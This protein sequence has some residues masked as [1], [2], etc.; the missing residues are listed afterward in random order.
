MPPRRRLRAVVC[1]DN[2]KGSCKAERV[3]QAIV[4]GLSAAAPQVDWEFDAVPMT[5]GGAGFLS[6]LVAA[7][8]TLEVVSM[9][10]II[11]PLQHALPHA[12]YA[13]DRQ[14][15]HAFIEM[16]AAAGIEHVPV[17]ERNPLRTTTFGVG[18]MIRHAVQRS[19]ATKVT[20]GL[21]GSA[22]N[23]GALGML[24]ALG[25]ALILRRKDGKEVEM[26]NDGSEGFAC[27]QTLLELVSIKHADRVL[28]TLRPKT[29]A[30]VV[31]VELVTDVTNVLTGAHGATAVYG[32]QKG[33]TAEMVQ[34]LDAAMKRYAT[35]LAR[36]FGKD[37]ENEPGAGAA[38]G[39]GAALIAA[40]NAVPHRGA[41]AFASMVKLKQRM[42]D[43]DVVITGEGCFDQQTLAYGKTA[44][45]VMQLAKEVALRRGTQ[46]PVVVV[47]G[48][49]EVSAEEAA[50]HGVR[51]TL[52]LR[53]M[54]SREEAVGETQRCIREMLTENVSHVMR[55][56]T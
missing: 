21:G 49:K 36:A 45:V 30:P 2:F 43:A 25:A 9:S 53:D 32:P 52:V 12:V 26:L 1:C 24:Q 56:F 3:N 33:A 48:R 5:D 38:G 22:T 20:I 17:E 39:M 41:A 16:A 15:G 46:L 54:F 29:G 37:V 51:L 44:A 27:G 13:L 7:R 18:Q 28:D 55:I 31:H 6:A 8:P 50:E 19:R 35:V 11:G 42:Q 10:G 23:D 14:A 4:D 34:Q 47:C 40:A